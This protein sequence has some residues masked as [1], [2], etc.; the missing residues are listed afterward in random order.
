[1]IRS[2]G[3]VAEM[4][5]AVEGQ[6]VMLAQRVEGDRPLDHLTDQTVRVASALG[7]ER[8]QQLRIALVARGR[9]VERTQE[10][11][12]GAIRRRCSGLH[13][14]RREDLGHE[15][16]EPLP[17]R[18]L[19]VPRRDALLRCGRRQIGEI[20][21][22]GGANLHGHTLSDRSSQSTLSEVTCAWLRPLV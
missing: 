7:R 16:G 5:E 21:V 22:S 14:E 19:D 6:R 18:R 12:G 13:S 1:M 3:D 17:V 8:R 2:C 9:V 11:V 15:P 20:L 4:H 10:P